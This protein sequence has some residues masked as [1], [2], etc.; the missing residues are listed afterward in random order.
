MSASPI[1]ILKISGIFS[2]FR[3]PRVL[4]KETIFFFATTPH[5][6]KSRFFQLFYGVIK[7]RCL[8]HFSVSWLSMLYYFISTVGPW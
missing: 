3:T 8:G 7:V 2:V 1:E 6:T 4:F 5:E